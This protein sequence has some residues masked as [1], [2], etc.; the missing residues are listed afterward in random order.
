MVFEDMTTNELCLAMLDA[1][2]LPLIECK[3]LHAEVQ[4]RIWES[5][6]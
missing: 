3:R 5:C 4:K 6:K 1:E 2:R